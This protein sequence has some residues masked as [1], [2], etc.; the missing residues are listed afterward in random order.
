MPL[1]NQDINCIKKLGFNTNFFI[2]SK[3]RWL[4]L[5][6]KEGKCVFNNGSM[7]LIYKN[8]PEGCRL[9]PVIYDKDESCAILDKDCPYKENFKITKKTAEELFDIVLKLEKEKALRKIKNI[10]KND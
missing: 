3:N 4:Q 1:S 9:Y 6:N 8:R 10:K 5:K 7:C 2:K